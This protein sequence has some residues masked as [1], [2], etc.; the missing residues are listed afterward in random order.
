MAVFVYCQH[1][2][3]RRN[4]CDVVARRNQQCNFRQSIPS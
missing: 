3:S 4:R 1:P 2:S